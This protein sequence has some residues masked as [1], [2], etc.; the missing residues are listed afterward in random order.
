MSYGPDIADGVAAGRYLCR[1][2]PEGREA[3]R[4]ADRAARTSSSLVINLKTAGALATHDS[5]GAAAARGRA[6][7]MIVRGLRKRSA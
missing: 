4:H 5:P 1:Q 7:S 6:A 3:G 2:G